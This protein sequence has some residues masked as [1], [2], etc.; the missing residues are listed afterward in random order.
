MGGSIARR[1]AAAIV[2]CALASSAGA[3]ERD[4]KTRE[5]M[6]AIFEAMRVALPASLE[7][8]RFEDPEARD[9]IRA[10]L[11]TLARN[12]RRLEAHG[13]SGE[14]GFRYLSRSLARDARDIQH[15]YDSGRTSEARFLLQELTETCV[16]CHSRLPSDRRFPLGE[17]FVDETVIAVV[18]LAERA[19][20]ETA[21][22]QFDRAL[23]TFELLFAAPDAAPDDLSLTGTI[24]DYLEIAIRVRGDTARPLATLETLSRRQ[25]LSKVMRA[26]LDS[27]IR[28]LRELRD[29]KPLASPIAEARELLRQADDR[30][31]FPGRR[32][33]LVHYV[34][35]SRALHLYVTAQGEPAPELAEA[36]YLLGVI[37]THVGRSLWQSQSEVYLEAA[38]R[39]DPRGPFA[40]DAFDL[41]ADTVTSGWTGSSGTHVPPGVTAHLDELR[42]LMSAP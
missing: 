21:T 37:E 42:D 31:R 1:I 19:R 15:L 14:A 17:R 25:D 20:Y 4:A 22:R 8:D 2:A 9:A 6:D 36:Y 39:V 7:D 10:A 23:A 33:A 35:A 27:W 41:L 34:F 13:K 18:P 28:S 11:A 26:N 3:D 16:A 24:D 40:D 32:A 5:T 38:I 12:G 29:R 30:S